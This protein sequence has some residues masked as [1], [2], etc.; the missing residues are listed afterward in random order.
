MTKSDDGL[1]CRELEILKL[2]AE[3]NTIKDIAT[4][5]SI[6]VKTSDAHKYNLMRKLGLHNTG[7]IVRY[8]VEQGV[9]EILVNREGSLGKFFTGRRP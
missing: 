1:T 5:L 9:I 7:S 8:A 6:S 2:L 4:L 3:G